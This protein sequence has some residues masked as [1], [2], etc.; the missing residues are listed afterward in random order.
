M[1]YFYILLLAVIIFNQEIEKNDS[2]EIGWQTESALCPKSKGYIW[3]ATNKMAEEL[4]KSQ[5]ITFHTSIY[6]WNLDVIRHK[7]HLEKHQKWKGRDIEFRRRAASLL[8]VFS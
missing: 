5:S 8:G 1:T 2:S 4:R 6:Y 3:S 7:L